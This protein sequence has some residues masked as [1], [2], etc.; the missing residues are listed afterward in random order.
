[1]V[2]RLPSF[3][4]WLFSGAFDVSFREDYVVPPTNQVA[5]EDA[6]PMA[7]GNLGDSYHCSVLFFPVKNRLK[8]AKLQKQLELFVKKWL[9][10]QKYF[11][12]LEKFGEHYLS[13][14]RDVL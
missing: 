2:E 1:M 4:E 5:K 9:N 11:C 13:K 8:Y 7:I 10:K 14:S 3:L 6:M 12:M